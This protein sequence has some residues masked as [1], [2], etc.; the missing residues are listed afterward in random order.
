[1]SGLQVGDEAAVLATVQSAQARRA[2]DG[3]AVVEWSCATTR[4]ASRSSSSTSPGG[5]SSWRPA[6]RRIFFG[7]VDRVPGHAADGQPRGRRGGGRHAG[8]AHAAHPARLPGLGQGRAH[9][10]GDRGVR[11]RGARAG[12][13]VRRPAAAESARPHRPVGPHRGLPG[14]PRAGVAAGGRAGAPPAGLRRALP[15]AAGPGT[16][17][18]GLRGQRPRPAPRRVAAGDHRGA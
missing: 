12:R 7:K 8:A 15:A 16:A 5:P 9:V 6:P 4:A 17:A 2:R 10:V 1:M 18:A 14:H 3:R 11:G 13:G